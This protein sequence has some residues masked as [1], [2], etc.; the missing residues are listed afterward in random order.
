MR[1]IYR[2]LSFIIPC[3]I[4]VSAQALSFRDVGN[5][6]GVSS[7]GPA[8]NDICDDYPIGSRKG[9]ICRSYPKDKVLTVE[10]LPAS[11]DLKTD[12]LYLVSGQST[13]ETPY[14]LQTGTSVLPV[15]S[16]NELVLTPTGSGTDDDCGLCVVKFAEGT[17][18]AGLS[19]DINSSSWKPTPGKGK[20]RAIFYGATSSSELSESTIWG[21]SDFVD[22]VHQYMTVDGQNMQSYHGL[23]LYA[24]GSQNLLRLENSDSTSAVSVPD[25]YSWHVDIV[26]SIGTLSGDIPSSATEQGGFVINNLVGT[27]LSSSVFYT[28]LDASKTF[29][30]YGLIATDT[31][32]LYVYRN[33]HKVTKENYSREQDFEE[34]YRN[35]LQ[36][37]MA[38]FSDD[39]SYFEDGEHYV[40]ELSDPSK[41]DFYLG[42][43]QEYVSSDVDTS[44]ESISKLTRYG[45][46]FLGNTQQLEHMCPVNPDNYN[47]SDPYP[48]VNGLQIDF[49]PSNSTTKDFH[50][51]CTSNARNA[52]CERSTK[53][54]LIDGSIGLGIGIAVTSAIW[55]GIT[56][57]ICRS[58]GK[59]GGYTTV[60]GNTN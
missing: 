13:I 22:L 32:E 43:N 58:V 48:V 14:P 40:N 51:F 34:V 1:R 12:T 18:L 60:Q 10:T 42:N 7:N 44:P 45:G 49:G 33:S 21:R 54:R 31:P 20:E 55:I 3:V 24:E 2:P 57:C 38:V 39:N 4:S 28:P 8:Y 19:V 23:V 26:N 36:S 15:P 59:K 6:G 52:A 41:L 47:A 27:I 35:K 37:G 53:D 17:R 30:R 56:V 50:A 29:R 11:K 25:T 5:F 9:N 46:F 16:L